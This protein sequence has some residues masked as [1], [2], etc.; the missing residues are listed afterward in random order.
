MR[1]HDSL[2]YDYKTR[3][4]QIDYFPGGL[5]RR[6]YFFNYQKQVRQLYQFSGSVDPTRRSYKKALERK[7]KRKKLEEEAAENGE[8]LPPLAKGSN[9]L[10]QADNLVLENEDYTWDECTVRRRNATLARALSRVTPS[11]RGSP[12]LLPLFLCLPMIR[13]GTR[14][15]CAWF[16]DGGGVA[17]RVVLR[18]WRVCGLSCAELGFGRA[19]PFD[20]SDELLHS[21]K[22]SV[23][24]V[25]PGERSER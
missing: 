5:V 16:G 19:V 25:I 15:L 2:T 1:R 6:T 8:E 4:L 22:R 14:R 17:S 10:D 9:A 21:G 3:K 23:G 11:V 20:V 13:C 7:A 24:C 18:V 12:L